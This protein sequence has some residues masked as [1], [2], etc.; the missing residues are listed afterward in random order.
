MLESEKAHFIKKGQLKKC[1]ECRNYFKKLKRVYYSKGYY[2]SNYSTWLC[3]KCYS[4]NE[5][6]VK[7]L[8]QLQQQTI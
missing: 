5:I 6:K 4:Q 1:E 3:D 8:K 2:Y 7:I